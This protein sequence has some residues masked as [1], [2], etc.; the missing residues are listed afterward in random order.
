MASSKI[1][2]HLKRRE[3]EEIL[4]KIMLCNYKNYDKYDDGGKEERK[5]ILRGEERRLL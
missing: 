2:A 3:R 5:I 4:N 1:H